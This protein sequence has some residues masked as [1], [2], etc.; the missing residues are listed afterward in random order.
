MLVLRNATTRNR[1]QNTVR[2]KKKF[3][4][5]T[6]RDAGSANLVKAD[7]ENLKAKLLELRKPQY[8]AEHRP[9]GYWEKLDQQFDQMEDAFLAV[10]VD[11][12]KTLDLL[13]QLKITG[14]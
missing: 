4:S 8:E 2:G 12:Q 5:D 9:G 3:K 14:R 7:V 6:T 13:S 11:K 1:F 10:A